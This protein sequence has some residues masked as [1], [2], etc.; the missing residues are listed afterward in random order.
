MVFELSI[1]LH[2]I[3]S[4]PIPELIPNILLYPLSVVT[5][6]RSISIPLVE[7]SILSSASSVFLGI[8]IPLAKSFPEPVGITP[9][10][11]RSKSVI[12][13]RTSFMVPSPPTTISLISSSSSSDILFASS[14]ACPPYFVTYALYS[15]PFCLSSR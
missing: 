5:S 3:A 13:F 7:D 8:F 9:N 6:P 2:T 14:E 12:P 15:I 11:I 1:F 10:L 4:R